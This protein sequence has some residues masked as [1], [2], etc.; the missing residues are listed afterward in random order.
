MCLVFFAFQ[1]G[2]V[3]QSIDVQGSVI[4]RTTRLPV[5]GARVRVSGS[6]GDHKAHEQYTESDAEGRFAV[7]VPAP[8]RFSFSASAAGYSV[9]AIHRQVTLVL[10][11]GVAA[12]AVV[13]PIERSG[14]IEGTLVDSENGSPVPHLSVTAL[15]LTFQR[16]LRQSWFEGSPVSTDAKGKFK[17]G[18]LPP[19]E[20]VLEMDS[21]PWRPQTGKAPS[22]T[23][24]DARYGRMLWPSE[25]LQAAAP[26][27]LG[28]GAEL[29]AG[30]IKIA[31]GQS[32]KLTVS[33]GACASDHPIAVELNQTAGASRFSRGVLAVP[34]GKSIE[35]P[36]V[37][38][39]SYELVGSNSESEYAA[40]VF[41]MLRVDQSV[42]LMLKAPLPIAG[43]LEI[44]G[45]SPE[46]GEKVKFPSGSVRLFPRG[47]LVNTYISTVP[48]MPAGEVQPD[49]TFSTLVHDPP[50]G[51]VE[52]TLHGF[53]AGWFLKG[54]EYNLTPVA[55]K[56]F[57]LDPRATTQRLKV[58]ISNT[59]ATIRGTVQDESGKPFAG[60][61]VLAVRWPCE[62][63]SGYPVDLIEVKAG[64]D[65]SF[66]MENLVSGTYRALAIQPE[67]RGSLELPGMLYSTLQSIDV[68]AVREG[69]VATLPL[70]LLKR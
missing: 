32:A 36:G 48:G 68:L 55:G 22:S 31:K 12:P 59:P 56:R 40:V 62:T 42:E 13:L 57:Q 29:R 6:Y 47:M 16:G 1:I 28:A 70:R 17:L 49:G 10:K 65:G 23:H 3:A 43:T 60:A 5:A 53:P 21:S 38:P 25:S 14:S 9:E 8:G 50:G 19:G 45:V 44:A 51:L 58:L 27:L 52:V 35:V 33:V 26:V 2:L 64:A 39:G 4:E 34:C 63:S 24:A 7:T 66:S 61:Q 18:S 67:L 54:L 15:R 30:E 41:E 20:Y 37:V 46:S 69:S 11:S